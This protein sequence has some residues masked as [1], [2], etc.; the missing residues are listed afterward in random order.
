M[1]DDTSLWPQV[2]GHADRLLQLLEDRRFEGQSRDAAVLYMYW[3]TRR[4]YEAALVLLK[5]RLPEEAAI[6]GRS[7]FE[8]AMRL[9]QLAADPDDRDVLIIGWV[10]DS[11]NRREGLFHT[12][13]S[14]GLDPD[15]QEQLAELRGQRQRLD[16]YAAGRR[17]K[18]FLE[19]RGAAIRFNR[20]DDFW[21]YEWAHQSTHGGEASSIFST[22]VEGDTTHLHAKTDTP[23]VLGGFVHFAARAMA[24]AVTATYTI[25][26]WTPVPDFEEPVRAMEELLAEDQ[27]RR[28]S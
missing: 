26:G 18:P 6:I 12:A 22:R 1:A 13:E 23:S 15:V 27:A 17:W 9:M 21:T 20:R 4:L 11:I 5:A 10:G 24:D 7:L 25:L 2:S 3:R 8:T 19:P 28:R 16:E 14:L